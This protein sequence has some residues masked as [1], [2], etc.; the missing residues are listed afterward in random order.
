MS[1][2]PR[3]DDAGRKAR[4]WLADTDERSPKFLLAECVNARAQEFFDGGTRSALISA[5]QDRD[6]AVG[7]LIT[8]CGVNLD[9]V[10]V[11]DEPEEARQNAVQAATSAAWIQILDDHAPLGWGAVLNGYVRACAEA[12]DGDRRAALIDLL[13]RKCRVANQLVLRAFALDLTDNQ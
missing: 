8:L 2:S 4:A 10:P 3:T 6:P 5:L 1:L 13:R 9:P 7:D 11:P 12:R